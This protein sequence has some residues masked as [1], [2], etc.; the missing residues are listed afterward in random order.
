MS[1]Q[2]FVVPE[3]IFGLDSID[4]AGSSL[5][6]LGA[7]R[8]FLVTDP[9]VRSYGWVDRALPSLREAG[10]DY[11]IWDGVSEN[12]KD[13]EVHHGAELFLSEECDALLAVGGGSPIDAAKSVAIIATNGGRII[14]YAGIDRISLP[15]PPMVMVPSTGGT[16]ADVSQFAIITDKRRRVKEV[17]C[18]KSLVP[19]ISITDPRLLTTK[20]SELTAF[21]G[22]D[23]LTHA[24]E[25]YVSVAATPLTDVHALSAVE[26]IAQNLRQSVACKDNIRA[27]VNMAMASLKAGICLS[28]ASLGAA[29]A[30]SHQ[31]GG[32]F[33]LPHG[34]VNA[35]ILPH[36]MEYNLISDTDR[37]ARVAQ[38]MGE[39]VEG[40]SSRDAA[41]RAVA[42]VRNL[43]NDIGIPTR[44][45]ETEPV[46]DA[47]VSAMVEQALVDVCL[48]TN[49]RDLDAER[50]E[51][52]FRAVLICE[53]ELSDQP[54]PHPVHSLR[55]LPLPPLRAQR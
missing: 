21:T 14:D 24:I 48:A 9:G 43:A 38:A 1:I 3:V 31:I 44:L 40:L 37:Y 42:A 34:M 12:P 20:P 26:L 2:K 30:A 23:A 35:I 7:R 4:Q 13:V 27:K 16:G 54:A 32:L 47:A 45:T 18:S 52:L 33:D 25:A 19:D 22:M 39:K 5:G 49:P 6:R 36:I 46:T 53:R 11:V 8:V 10:L 29:H 55:E 15:L 51:E 17:I 41:L 50:M 28:N